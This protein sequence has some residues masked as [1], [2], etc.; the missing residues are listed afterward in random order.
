LFVLLAPLS[1]TTSAFHGGDDDP[2]TYHLELYSAKGDEIQLFEH[3]VHL[4]EAESDELF[5]LV[6]GQVESAAVSPQLTLHLERRPS[7]LDGLG[8]GSILA[9]AVTPPDTLSHPP[10]EDAPRYV[11]VTDRLV[12]DGLLHRVIS[13]EEDSE[14][15][16]LQLEQATLAD[17]IKQGT[18]VIEASRMIR[19][20]EG[21]DEEMFG[22]EPYI[23]QE[24]DHY[25]KVSLYTSDM[26]CTPGRFQVDTSVYVDS[27]NG[28]EAVIEYSAVLHMTY[29]LSFKG[30]HLENAELASEI[31]QM[32]NITLWVNQEIDNEWLLWK[33][34]SRPK[35]FRVGWLPVVARAGGSLTYG[36]ATSGEVKPR[37]PILFRHHVQRQVSR[38]HG[39]WNITGPELAF[40]TVAAPDLS[41][42]IEVQATSKLVPQLEVILY[43]VAGPYIQAEGAVTMVSNLA[44]ADYSLQAGLVLQ[45]GIQQD[46]EV[47]SLCPLGEC[48][49]TLNDCEWNWDFDQNAFSGPV[50]K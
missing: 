1:P 9:A 3:V 11:N 20:I 6:S 38:S 14:G 5:S 25:R 30:G 19:S 45:A 40:P 39:N 46:N 32:G 8:S 29:A 26:H 42:S 43:G 31:C 44:P 37:E 2:E 13:L 48:E 35:L 4:T 36:L 28:M 47:V 49:K 23:Y 24:G 10:W 50:C 21:G 18:L 34:R 16:R 15:W 17:A 41:P 12:W 7:S 27:E 22:Q 33:D